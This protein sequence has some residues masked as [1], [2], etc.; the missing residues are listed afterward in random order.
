MATLKETIKNSTLTKKRIKSIIDR[1]SLF[2][3]RQRANAIKRAELKEQEGRDQRQVSKM[4]INIEWKKSRNW[5]NNPTATAS[6]THIDGRFTRH[7]ATCSGC[8]YDKEST[9]IA[10]IFNRTM[11][12]RLHEMAKTRKVKPY[13]VSLPGEYSPYYHGGI[14]TSCYTAIAKFIGGKF[15]HVS[16]GSTFDVYEL[17]MKAKK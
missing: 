3:D 13:G 7:T 6:V 12:Y 17:T 8:G 5:G 15:K 9:V 1:P 16:S 11:L 10:D 4:I 2:T 14:G